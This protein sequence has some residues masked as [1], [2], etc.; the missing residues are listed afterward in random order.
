MNPADRL[1]EIKALV[2]Y[3]EIYNQRPT[4][5]F[6]KTLL[7]R[8][9]RIQFLQLM[10]ALSSIVHNNLG[11]AMD[12]AW[13]VAFVRSLGN[14]PGSDAVL[15]KLIGSKCVLLHAVQI[16]L[17]CRYAFQYCK[18]EAAVDDFSEVILRL[19]LATNEL[20]TN[21]T[22]RRKSTSPRQAFFSVEVQAGTLPNERLA[23]VMQR[24][25]RFFQWCNRLSEDADDYL[26]LNSDFTRLMSMSP[27][28]YL[29]AAFSVMTAFLSIKSVNDLQN[30]PPL[31]NFR[32]FG[33]TLERR[34]AL[35]LW[36]GR[37][38]QADSDLS[39]PT[40]EPTF[41]V[42]DLAPFIERPLVTVE[43]DYICCPLPSLLEDTL[44][45]R[46]YFALFDA[47]SFTDGLARAKTFSRLQGHFF[48]I[49]CRRAYHYDGC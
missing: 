43:K 6:L 39:E 41:S 10:C 49:V 23:N 16:G 46:L 18:A 32:D 15:K 3:S 14:P 8:L 29:A 12:Q 11:V 47:Y 45:T 13:Q 9:N 31:L 48:R 37:F 2:L 34:E 44:N 1:E 28:E 20:Y 21:G 7:S 35:D 4:P 27:G 40:P 19:L 42:A 5:A 38:S 33:S 25:Y 26:P 22:D 36:I 30:H 24:Y 17:L